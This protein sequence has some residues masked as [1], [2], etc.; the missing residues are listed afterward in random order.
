MKWRY[1]W[2]SGQISHWRSSFEYKA[3]ALGYRF[4]QEIEARSSHWDKEIWLL[5]PEMKRSN[6]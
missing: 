4:L 1:S 2:Q 5:S 6:F 3:S